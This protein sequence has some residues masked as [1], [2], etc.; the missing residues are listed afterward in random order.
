[1]EAPKLIVAD[2]SLYGEQTIR[3]RQTSTHGASVPL[4]SCLWYCVT[5]PSKFE[6]NTATDVTPSVL[7]THS[8]SGMGDAPLALVT[9]AVAII[10]ELNFMVP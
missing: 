6:L 10:D 1:M 7:S 4:I 5:V 3:H 2:Y 9:K 8:D